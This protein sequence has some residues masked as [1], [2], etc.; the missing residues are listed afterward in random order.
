MMSVILA[1]TYTCKMSITLSCLPLSK[2]NHLRKKKQGQFHS[3]KR[4]EIMLLLTPAT[5]HPP[6][7]L[8]QWH[9]E[10]PYLNIQQ[11]S[12]TT[13]TTNQKAESLTFAAGSGCGCLQHFSQPVL[14]TLQF[15]RQDQNMTFF[16]ISDGSWE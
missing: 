12:Q 7:L 2:K 11:G 4:K 13:E 10:C 14:E 3:P 1:R 15:V 9:G 16:M 8:T 5:N 6:C